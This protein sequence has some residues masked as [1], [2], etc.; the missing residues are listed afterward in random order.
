MT[1][2]LFT[3]KHKR[4]MQLTIYLLIA[5]GAG[6]WLTAITAIISTA[7]IAYHQKTQ[8]I[9]MNT[10]YSQNYQ[11]TE[12]IEALEQQQNTPVEAETAQ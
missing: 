8:A 6:A 1:D 12:H 7:Q 4:R 3:K 9:Q 5:L 2:F 10:L 11:L